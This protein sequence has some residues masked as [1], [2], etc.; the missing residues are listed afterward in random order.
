MLNGELNLSEIVNVQFPDNQ[1]FKEEFKKTQIYLHHTAGNPSG[2]GVFSYWDDNTEKVA[3][4]VA[5]SG[6]GKGTV[7]GQIVQG[8]SSKFWAYHLGLKQDIFT[9][10]G[11]KYQSLDK[12]S[13]GIEIC[14]WGF[15]TKTER[16]WETYVGALIPETEVVEYEQP[17]KGHKHYQ[18][19][20][21][22]QIESVYKLLKHWGKTYGID[23]KF[24][25]EAIF[26]IDERALKGES[27]IFTHNSVRADK[28][29]IHPQKEVIQMLKAL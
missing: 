19:Y 26:G 3:T 18:R 20:T 25:G 23:T 15:V 21:D 28:T 11:V 1:Y 9:K 2:T 7:D 17:F 12:I 8:F 14:N 16:G 4:C 5:I 22:A 13:I 10:T 6:K 29:D 27:G 24:K